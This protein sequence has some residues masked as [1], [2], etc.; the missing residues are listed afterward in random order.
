MVDPF[1]ICGERGTASEHAEVLKLALTAE[2]EHEKKRDAHE[3]KMVERQQEQS[4]IK[5]TSTSRQALAEKERILEEWVNKETAL[6]KNFQ[7]DMIPHGK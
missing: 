6:T 7:F 1:G 5:W 4:K 2:E 3:Q